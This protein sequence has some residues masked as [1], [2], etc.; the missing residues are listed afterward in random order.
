MLKSD[1]QPLRPTR[2][3]NLNPDGTEINYRNSH[4][5][6][7]A[8]HWMQVDAEEIK[9]LFTSDTIRPIFFH[10]IDRTPS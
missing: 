6:P 10:D 8:R 2:P 9:R 1:L 3:L 4:N 5:G 7:N